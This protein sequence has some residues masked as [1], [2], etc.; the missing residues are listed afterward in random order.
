MGARISAS[1]ATKAKTVAQQR[2][3]QGGIGRSAPMQ[4]TAR[5]QLAGQ[6]VEALEPS[7]GLHA[8]AVVGGEPEGALGD[9]AIPGGTFENRLAW[10]QS[11]HGR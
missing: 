4:P 2:A 11:L 8:R 1:R 3:D 6:F 9:I 10:L 5:A 7:L